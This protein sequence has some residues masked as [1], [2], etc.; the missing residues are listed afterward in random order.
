ME[1][2][3]AERGVGTRTVLDVLNAEQEL[4]SS[5]LTL[6]SARRDAYVTGFQ[7]LTVMGQG[8]ADDLGLDGGPLYD[9]TRNYH[10]VNRSWSDWAGERRRQPASTR[11]IETAAVVSTE[12]HAAPVG[13]TEKVATVAKPAPVRITPLVQLGGTV[14]P[15][16][17]APLSSA[18]GRWQIQLGAFRVV[19]APQALYDRLSGGFAGKKPTYREFG[20]LTRLLIGPYATKAEALAAC[21]TLKAGQSCFPVQSD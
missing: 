14:D 1:G 5:Q 10:R 4:L 3:R 11:T 16:A 13:E 6:V 15:Q 2:A 19:G 17:T 21:R 20:S 12:I 9:P 18:K 7:L 8:E